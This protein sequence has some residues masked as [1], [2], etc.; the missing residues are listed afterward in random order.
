MGRSATA[1]AA[2]ILAA[3][4]LGTTGCGE[5]YDLADREPGPGGLGVEAPGNSEP[6]NS[7][8]GN[9]K[10]T[11]AAILQ[12][13]SSDAPTEILLEDLV[14]TWRDLDEYA[15]AGDPQRLERILAIWS[16]LEPRVI[17]ERPDLHFGF[18]QAIDLAITSVERRRPGDAGKGL[19]IAIEVSNSYRNG[20]EQP[21]SN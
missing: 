15:I 10:S 11:S 18:S 6:G 8:S 17:E 7:E 4:A 20:N 5:T 16:I 3:I 21:G 12:A 19:R 13:P 9:S 1:L 14:T 2:M